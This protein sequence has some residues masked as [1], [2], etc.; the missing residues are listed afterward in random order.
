MSEWKTVAVPVGNKLF[1]SHSYTYMHAGTTYNLE[2]DEFS[3][4]TY[5]GHGEHSTDKSSVVE[6]VAGASIAECL[7]KLID[8]IQSRN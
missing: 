8:R 7:Q 1:K 4:G 6:S 5:S 3:D 2:V